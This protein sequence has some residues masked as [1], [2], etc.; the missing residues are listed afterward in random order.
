MKQNKML[1]INNQ[2]LTTQCKDKKIP[3]NCFN[4]TVDKK[5]RKNEFS[6]NKKSNK[7]ESWFIALIKN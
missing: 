4:S 5:K 3:V 6:M 1:L 7:P 2:Q